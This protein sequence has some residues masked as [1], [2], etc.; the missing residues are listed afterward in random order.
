LS[1]RPLT[2]ALFTAEA[3]LLLVREAGMHFLPL[4]V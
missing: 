1:G 3:G 2:A 4:L